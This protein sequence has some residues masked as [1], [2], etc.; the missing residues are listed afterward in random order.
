ME[1]DYSRLKGSKRSNNQKQCGILDW[2][3]FPKTVSKAPKNVL[4]QLD[5]FKSG[6]D[7]RWYYEIIAN[8][9]MT[10]NSIMVM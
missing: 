6:L 4:I 2:F 5:K 9:L 3:L 8:F 1:C 10:H 7:I